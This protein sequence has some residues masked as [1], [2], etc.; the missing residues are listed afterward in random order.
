[1]GNVKQLYGV[2]SSL[3]GRVKDNPLPPHTSDVALANEFLHFFA[4]KIAKIRDELDNSIIE[5]SPSTD[6]LS[7]P[8]VKTA[9][10][11]FRTLSEMDISKLS[12]ES[13]S[14]R[15]E[16]DVIPTPKLKDNLK[17]LTPVITEIVNQSLETGVYPQEWKSAVIRPLLKKKGLSLEL[18]NYRPVSNLSFLSKIL[19]KAALCQI[20]EYIEANKLLPKYQSAYRKKPWCRNCDDEDVQ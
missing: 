15:C 11:E 5:E 8:Q 20:T 1:M 12:R 13:K 10:T 7:S 19:E 2:I 3:L 6:N 4:Q 17:Y 16:L 9:F 18:H 14:T